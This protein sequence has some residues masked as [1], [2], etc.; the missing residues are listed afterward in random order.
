MYILMLLLIFPLNLF[1][2]EPV[3]KAP[4]I[5]KNRTHRCRDVAPD[6]CTLPVWMYE[7]P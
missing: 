6:L 1:I 7:V 3:L 2:H 5:D 4:E